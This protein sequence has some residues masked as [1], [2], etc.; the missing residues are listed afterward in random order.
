MFKALQQT[1]CRGGGL[2]G[3]TERGLKAFEF[4][5]QVD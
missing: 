5:L 4:L 3:S 1:L 2:L